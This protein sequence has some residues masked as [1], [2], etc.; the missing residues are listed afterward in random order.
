MGVGG[1]S[2][3]MGVKYDRGEGRKFQKA[4]ST[5]ASVS[6]AFGRAVNSHREIEIDSTTRSEAGNTLCDR[7]F[8]DVGISRLEKLSTRYNYR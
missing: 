5:I 8:F 6:I 2:S 3:V 4:K 1:G 7:F